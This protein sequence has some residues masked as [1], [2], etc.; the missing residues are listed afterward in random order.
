M[1]YVTRQRLHVD[2]IATAWAIRRFVDP[3]AEFEFVARTGDVPPGAIA[4]DIRGAELGHH[5]GRCTFE[6]LLEL[7]ELRNPALNA[8][9]LIIRGADLPDEP[10][11]PAESIGV[12]AIFDGIRAAYDTDLERLEAGRQVC[13]ALYQY[14]SG[15]RRGP[16]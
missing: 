9:G 3:Q 10:D 15:Q 11:A 7:H 2:R 14:C 5:G 12:T 4:F 13:D 1:R 8:M 16:T 6:T